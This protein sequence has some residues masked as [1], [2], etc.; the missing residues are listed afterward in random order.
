MSEKSIQVGFF[1]A[2]IGVC[3]GSAIFSALC[4]NRWWRVVLHALILIF[5]LSTAITLGEIYRLHGAFD[6]T[7]REFSTVFGEI[8]F[9]REGVTPELEAGKERSLSLPFDGR[10]V[11]LPDWKRGVKFSEQDLNAFRYL[12]FWSQ[13]RLIVAFNYGAEQ[14]WYV[15]IQQPDPLP[16]AHENP[17]MP[18]YFKAQLLKGDAFSKLLAQPALGEKEW[19]FKEPFEL[20]CD[21]L[22]QVA[23]VL[24]TGT[25]FCGYF[26]GTIL[27]TILYIGLFGLMFRLTGG[28]RRLAVL[29]FSDF[30]KI[31]IYAGFPAL[32]VAACFPALDLP[33]FGFNTIYMIGLVI[34]WLSVVSRLEQRSNDN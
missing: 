17:I 7:A 25:V 31:G 9:S 11:Y 22:L 23:L 3:R 15:G 18:I 19:P 34:Y 21:E 27:L 33:F 26:F 20:E 8:K 6:T 13:R 5:L 28:A 1:S 14:G 4:G 16:G 29:N 24:F 30:C 12:C 10:L 2:L 32:I